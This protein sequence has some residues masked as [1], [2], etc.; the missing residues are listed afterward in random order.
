MMR[1]LPLCSPPQAGWNW[2][3][4]VFCCAT[5]G[6]SPPASAG[7]RKGITLILNIG[8]DQSAGTYNIC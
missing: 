1:A 2:A 4:R 5:A 6:L 8:N 3:T 7:G